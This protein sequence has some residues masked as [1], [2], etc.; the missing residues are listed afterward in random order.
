MS[1]YQSGV[2]AA[3]QAEPP[4]VVGR[5][6]FITIAGEEFRVSLVKSK[7]VAGYYV[8]FDTRQILVEHG[9]PANV[10][11]RTVCAIELAIGCVKALQA[12]ERKGGAE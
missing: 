8:H 2:E 9:T 5:S 6:R 7:H 1:Y 11:G 3:L 4:T 10:F 12:A